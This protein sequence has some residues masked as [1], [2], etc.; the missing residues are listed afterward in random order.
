[1]QCEAAERNEFNTTKKEWIVKG[2]TTNKKERIVMILNLVIL[3][4]LT[5]STR[6]SL[7]FYTLY[8]LAPDRNQSSRNQSN[9]HAWHE[10]RLTGLVKCS[11]NGRILQFLEGT[12]QWIDSSM[13]GR[14]RKVHK[15]LR[16]CSSEVLSS[17]VAGE[18]GAVVEDNYGGHLKAEIRD[19]SS[20]GSA[21]VRW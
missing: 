18:W 12:G 6:V 8:S 14:G 7:S 15:V 5:F 3:N 9:V 19:R 2:K 10:C 4:S 1:M 16:I 13:A 21:Q 17:W 11:P 20:V